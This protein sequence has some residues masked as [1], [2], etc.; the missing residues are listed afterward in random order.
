MNS[1]R[2]LFMYVLFLRRGVNSLWIGLGD[3]ENCSRKEGRKVHVD[4]TI[5]HD[6][7]LLN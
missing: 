7:I 2:F 6:K 1:S 3:L 5:A 4:C